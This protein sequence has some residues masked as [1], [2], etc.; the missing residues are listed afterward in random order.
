MDSTV[1]KLHVAVAFKKLSQTAVFLLFECTPRH[2]VLK[3]LSYYIKAKTAPGQGQGQG[4]CP[5]R[6]WPRRQVFVLKVSSRSRTVLEDPF[7]G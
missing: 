1:T 5:S 6:P 2:E 4:L 3:L 7:P